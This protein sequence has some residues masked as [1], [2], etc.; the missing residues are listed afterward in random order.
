MQEMMD[1]R[2]GGGWAASVKEVERVRRG[3][4]K[5]EE[6]KMGQFVA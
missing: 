6:T 3:G 4:E 2:S 1:R 5:E